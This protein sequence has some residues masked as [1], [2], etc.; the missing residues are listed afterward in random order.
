M[1]GAATAVRRR[2]NGYDLS[3]FLR[4]LSTRDG[5]RPF[6]PRTLPDHIFASGVSQILH[7]HMPDMRRH[8]SRPR[9]A[10][11]LRPIYIHGRIQAERD[12]TNAERRQ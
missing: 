11:L 6:V 8:A 10:Y 3:I 4:I 12:L 2:H 5:P 7:I 9:R 1:T